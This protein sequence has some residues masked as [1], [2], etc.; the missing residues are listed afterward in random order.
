MKLINH[1]LNVHQ[2]SKVFNLIRLF[3]IGH[4]PSTEEKEKAS[5]FWAQREQKTSFVLNN[6]RFRNESNESPLKKRQ[7]E[8]LKFNLKKK[9]HLPSDEK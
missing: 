3:R 8:Q 7:N 9:N 1:Y 2:K 4:S 5:F 6:F